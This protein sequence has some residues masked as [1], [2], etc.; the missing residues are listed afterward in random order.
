MAQ[1]VKGVKAYRLVRRQMNA[2]L[3]KADKAGRLSEELGKSDREGRQWLA[4]LD[5][6]YGVRRRKRA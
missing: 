2:R 1:P 5:R 3:V 4:D 6:K